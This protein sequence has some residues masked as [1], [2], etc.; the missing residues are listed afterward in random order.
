MTVSA[1]YYVFPLALITQRLSLLLMMFFALMISMLIGL[2]ILSFNLQHLIENFLIAT[3]FQWWESKQIPYIVKKN[4][5]A[6]QD[7]LYLAI[8]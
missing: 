5:I 2:L 7:I 1:R 6:V 3:L 4:M 8:F